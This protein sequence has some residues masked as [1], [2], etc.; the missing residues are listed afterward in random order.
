MTYDE[1]FTTWSTDADK[2]AD[3]HK[4]WLVADSDSD[5]KLTIADIY[6]VVGVIPELRESDVPEL[7]N[8]I[9]TNGDGIAWYTEACEAVVN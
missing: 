8:D 5:W 9:D 7:W 4:K 6:A 2:K 1:A 3:F